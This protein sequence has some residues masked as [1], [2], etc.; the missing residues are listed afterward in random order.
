MLRHVVGVLLLVVSCSCL[1]LDPVNEV[2]YD[3]VN[4]VMQAKGMMFICRGKHGVSMLGLG[5]LRMPVPV[6]IGS[7]DSV[8]CSMIAAQKD[9]IYVADAYEMTVYDTLNINEPLKVG[10]LPLKKGTAD[11]VLIANTYAYVFSTVRSANGNDH[12]LHIANVANP[13]DPVRVGSLPLKERIIDATTDDKHVFAVS[14]AGFIIAFDATKAYDFIIKSITPL[15]AAPTCIT[16]FR[17]FIY[18]GIDEELRIYNIENVKQLE[19][20]V[21]VDIGSTVR[22]LAFTRGNVYVATDVGLTIVDVKDPRHPFESGFRSISSPARSLEVYTDIAYIVT[23]DHRLVMIDVVPPADIPTPVP[24]E[25]VFK[26]SY[27]IEDPSDQAKATLIDTYPIIKLDAIEVEEGMLAWRDL[28]ESVYFDVPEWLLGA[29]AYI[30]TQVV[31][32]G[33]HIRLSCADPVCNAF[34]FLEHCLPCSTVSNGGLASILVT[35]GWAPSSCGPRFRVSAR[36]LPHQTVLFRKQFK[37]GQ[38]VVLPPLTKDA[39]FVGLGMKEGNKICNEISDRA[40]CTSR[41]LLCGWDEIAGGCMPR[42]TRCPRQD[43]VTNKWLTTEAVNCTK[44]AAEELSVKAFKD[45]I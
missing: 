10:G 28:G 35:D 7:L 24:T 33:L 38:I 39:R 14:T 3:G 2:A 44:C 29:T 45:V 5:N 23:A 40:E 9:Y 32:Q 17:E 15:L 4:Y 11:Y 13:E 26:A 41:N 16:M 21:K 12:S 19:E 25:V 42:I 20:A 31:R 22:D 1:Y 43:T 18:V 34:I 30:T 36:G 27:N 37:R 8:S 6:I